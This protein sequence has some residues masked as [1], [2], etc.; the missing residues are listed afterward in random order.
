MSFFKFHNQERLVDII[1]YFVLAGNYINFKAFIMFKQVSFVVNYTMI[2]LVRL[3]TEDGANASQSNWGKTKFEIMQQCRRKQK[4][5]P[6]STFCKGI[7]ING[8]TNMFR[9]EE[10]FEIK[11]GK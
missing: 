6:S 7:G 3:L 9:I 2:H 10:D 1:I 8:W 5:L 11:T 4:L